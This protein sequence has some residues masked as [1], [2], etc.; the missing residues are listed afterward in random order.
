MSYIESNL[1]NDENVIYKAKLHWV[2]F[3]WPIIWFV[4]AL[5]MYSSGGDSAGVASVVIFIS[6]L[7][8]IISFINYTTSEFGITSKRVLVK[9]GLIRRHSLEVLLAKVEGI[10]VHQ[11][12]LG[13]ILGYGS[14]IV[15]GTGGSKEPFHRIAAPLKFRKNAQEQIASVQD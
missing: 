9:T 1:M 15:S 11:G 8:G 14:I 2:V 12:L 6:I 4:I 10:Q 5:S 13:R 7:T 3:L